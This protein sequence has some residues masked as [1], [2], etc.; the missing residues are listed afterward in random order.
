L[1]YSQGTILLTQK[2]FLHSWS[3]RPFVVVGLVLLIT[4]FSFWPVL[5]NGFVQWDD[6]AHLLEQEVVR[7]ITPRN[8][9]AMFQT[10]VHGVYIPLTLLSFSIEYAFFQYDPFIYHLNNLLLH[11]VVVLFIYKIG[12]RLGLSLYPAAGAA[13][14]FGIHP[15]H[16]ESVAWVTERKDVL[17]GAFY[18]S[19]VWMYLKYL[20]SLRQGRDRKTWFL[21]W[22]YGL[23]VLS[24]LAKPM[25]LSL[26][27]IFWLMDWFDRRKFGWGMIWEKS[28]FALI[29]SGITLLSYMHHTR[30]PFYGNADSLW[31]WIWS[32]IFYIKKFIFPYILAPVYRIDAPVGLGHPAHL[33]SLAAF[34]LILLSLGIFRRNR[35]YMFGFGF[36][37]LSIFFLLRFDVARDTNVV[38][39]RWMY[40]PSLGFCYAI[41]YGGQQMIRKMTGWG[42]RYQI[43]GIMFVAL[44]LFF[45]AYKTY[46]QSKVWRH[47]GTLWFHQVSY[48][49]QE[50]IGLSNLA[51]YL[52]QREPVKEAVTVYKQ[53]MSGDISSDGSGVTETQWATAQDIV[54]EVRGLYEK[55]ARQ[56]PGAPGMH[57]RLGTFYQDLGLY[58]KAVQAYENCA[59]IYPGYEDV[60]Y[61]IALTYVQ[62]K[63]YA[64]AYA[65]VRRYEA[66]S[67]RPQGRINARFVQEARDWV[68]CESDFLAGHGIP[69]EGCLPFKEH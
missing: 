54:H 59:R 21:W 29:V 68:A 45:L 51:T 65:Y 1:A 9:Q 23:G 48:D 14:L 13:L 31:I 26:P 38:A 56:Q 5:G 18:L 7:D 60:L 50:P 64:R 15:V 61:K 66:L 42:K 52:R 8:I 39:D 41:A 63:D 62:L 46:N 69:Q 6:P 25:A 24:L 19:S 28:P 55:A 53:R 2:S 22:A 32:F 11:L 34:I 20:A 49:P 37:F 44:C 67:R 57:F 4:F 16:V 3:D 17:Y 40:L 27:L 58:H 47:T 43:A 33:L 10:H 12:R 30:V 35:W 36:Y